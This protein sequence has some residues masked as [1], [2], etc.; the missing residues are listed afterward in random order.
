MLSI[1]KFAKGLFQETHSLSTL[2]QQA[3][4]LDHDQTGENPKVDPAFA[5][6]SGGFLLT[7]NHS[8]ENPLWKM[9]FLLKWGILQAHTIHVLY[10]I[11]LHGC[12]IFMVNKWK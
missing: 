10:H 4:N 2:P 3:W 1:T 9:Y 5:A 7:P 6:T 11:Y 12:L 8:M